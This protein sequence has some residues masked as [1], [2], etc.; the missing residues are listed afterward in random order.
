MA[1]QQQVS[2]GAPAIDVPTTPEAATARIA[3][4]NS[5]KGWVEKFLAGDLAIRRENDRL[6]TI[7]AGGSPQAEPQAVTTPAQAKNRLDEL[8]TDAVWRRKFLD[9]D[10]AT[11]KE[12]DRLTEI[13]AQAPE[14]TAAVTKTLTAAEARARGT[15]CRAGQARR[16]RRATLQARRHA[17]ARGNNRD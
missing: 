6:L 12:F 13:A 9:G 2:T 15:R 7:A 11:K 1:D 5:D 8:N 3:E 4:L 10:L 16:V 14:G 17:D